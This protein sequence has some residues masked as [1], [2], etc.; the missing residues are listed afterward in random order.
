MGEAQTPHS[1]PPCCGAHP[2]PGN[3]C[4]KFCRYLTACLA[5][6]ALPGAVSPVGKQAAGE[7]MGLCFLLR[8]QP[9]GAGLLGRGSLSIWPW[10]QAHPSFLASICFRVLQP[11]NGEPPHLSFLFPKRM[12]KTSTYLPTSAATQNKGQF[13]GGGEG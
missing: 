4:A 5:R 12:A 2:T 1:N 13:R 7:K 8:N 10:E 11:R 9:V 3:C 6:P